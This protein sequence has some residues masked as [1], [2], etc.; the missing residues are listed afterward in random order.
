MVCTA[1]CGLGAVVGGGGTGGYTLALSV[2]FAVD[3][4]TILWPRAWAH[5][6]QA[7]ELGCYLENGAGVGRLHYQRACIADYIRKRKHC[8][9]PAGCSARGGGGRWCYCGQFGS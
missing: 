9:C 1:R 6:L 3:G 8:R 7:V 4:D 2:I 5:H